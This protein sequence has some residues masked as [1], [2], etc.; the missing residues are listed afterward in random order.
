MTDGREH[1]QDIAKSTRTAEA[2]GGASSR[3]GIVFRQI[4]AV[5]RKVPGLGEREG[6]GSSTSQGLGIRKGLV[7]L[8]CK[9][10]SGEQS[11][12]QDIMGDPV[13]H[14]VAVGHDVLSQNFPKSVLEALI[15]QEASK[16][17]HKKQ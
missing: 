5:L 12:G 1:C 10:K 3:T 16:K 4:L 6:K 15:L 14:G 13:V 17:S 9:N 8:K 7:L 2:P 11:L